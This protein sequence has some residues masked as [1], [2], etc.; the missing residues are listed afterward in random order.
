MGEISLKKTFNAIIQQDIKT[1]ML[2]ATIAELEGLV[3]QGKTMGELDKNI[4]EAIK[5][6]LENQK[7]DKITEFV[8]TLKYEMI[9]DEMTL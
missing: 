7:Y 3:T 5:L 6:H 9:Y 8:G 1:S 4:K 2:I